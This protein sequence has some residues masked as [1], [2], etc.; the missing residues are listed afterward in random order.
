[1]KPWTACSPTQ[2]RNDEYLVSFE[3]RNFSAWYWGKPKAKCL[4]RPDT[5]LAAQL[6]CSIHRAKEVVKATNGD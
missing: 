5:L 6:L 1:M 3:V 2:W 4:G